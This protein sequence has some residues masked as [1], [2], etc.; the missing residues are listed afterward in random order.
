VLVHG[1]GVSGRYMLPLAL[2]LAG[3]FSVFTPELPGW[4]RSQR[5]PVPL[6][7]GGLADALARCLDRLGLE[8]PAFVANSLGCQVVTDLAA[9]H[10]ERTGSLVLIGPTVDPKQRRARHQV[11]NGLRDAAREPLSLLALTARDDAVMGARAL[12]AT[13]RAALGDRIET[14]LPMIDRPTLVLCGEKDSFVSA[15]WAE[16]VTTLLPRARLVVVPGEPHA[17]HF[18]RPD[19]V[20]SLVR[21]FLVEE[22]EQPSRHRLGHLLHLHLPAWEKSSREL[23]RARRHSRAG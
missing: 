11:F 17:V 15:E 14:R 7:I 4:G 5:P 6:G 12:L 22:G 18:T 1:F 10:P 2:S 13:A 23:D 16:Q 21:A 3:Q 19:L 9:R 8:R 20:A